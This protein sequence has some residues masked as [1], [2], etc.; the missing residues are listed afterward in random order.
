M[1]ELKRNCLEQQPSQEKKTILECGLVG[2]GGV[3]GDEVVGGGSGAIVGAND[4]PLV[5][6][7]TTNH[8]DYDHIG[9][10]DFAP[11]SEC[12]ACKYQDCKAKLDGVIN[13]INALTTSVKELTSKRGGIPSKRILYPYTPSEIKAAKKRR[14]EIFKAPV[15]IEK[16]KIVT[17][18]SFSWTFDQCTRPTRAQHELKKITLTILAFQVDVTVEATAEQH[19][20]TVDNPSIASK[21]E[22]PRD[23]S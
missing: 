4:V 13:A 10:T 15:S 7:E 5:V 11:P 6:F 1:M 9:F 3:S 23:Q 17:P 12:S 22:D 18:L 20:I 14:K 16:S 21:D 2:G 19:N 8:Y